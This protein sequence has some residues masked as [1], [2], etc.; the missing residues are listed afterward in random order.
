MTYVAISRSVSS[1][2][3]RIDYKV[4]PYFWFRPLGE[5]CVVLRPV[6]FYQG[7]SAESALRSHAPSDLVA[8]IIEFYPNGRNLDDSRENFQ[9]VGV[10]SYVLEKIIEDVKKAGAQEVVILPSGR[11]SILNFLEKNGFEKPDRGNLYHRKI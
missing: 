10:G 3:S 11:S 7:S 1:D 9:R 5:S 6:S 2:H 8:E 4:H